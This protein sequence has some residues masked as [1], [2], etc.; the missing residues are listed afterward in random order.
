M[1]EY[2]EVS[3]KQLTGSEISIFV[4]TALVAAS[5]CAVLVSSASGAQSSTKAEGTSFAATASS[6]R[7]T[8][9]VRDGQSDFNFETG[10]WKTKVR[11]LRNPLSGKAAIWAEYDGTSIVRPLMNGRANIVDL[12][13]AGPAGRI[14]GV[15]LRLYEPKSR[16]WSLNFASLRDGK[17]T[18]PVVGSFDE[19]GRG[20]FYGVDTVGERPVRVRFVITQVSAREAHFDQAFSSDH[21]KTWE[22]NWV[23]VDTRL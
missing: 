2:G 5:G 4:R 20:V 11:V 16:Q 21:G 17:L 23:A 22:T 14:E 12:S 13:V 6:E 7:P 8:T 19:K 9:T 18:A 10:E 1:K 3:E 15:S